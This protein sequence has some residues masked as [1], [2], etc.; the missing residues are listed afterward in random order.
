MDTPKLSGHSI[1]Q[2]Q[3]SVT[4]AYPVPGPVRDLDLEPA[5]EGVSFNLRALLRK[6]WALL[7]ALVVV[8]AGA[9]FASVVL[10]TPMYKAH[11][12]LE[13]QNSPAGAM[14]GDNGRSSSDAQ[15]D[16]QT[17]IAVLRTGQFLKRGADRLQSE[18]VPVAPLGQDLFSHLR[19]RVHPATQDPLE[20]MR[21]GLNVAIGTFDARPVN[22]TRLIE[23]SCDS[24]NPDVAAGFLNAMAAEFVEDT[25]QSRMQ[26]SQ[27]AA[28]W[29]AGQIEETKA[30]V[31]EAEGKLRDFVKESGNRFAG[32]GPEGTLDDAKLAQ[33]KMELAKVQADRIAKQTRYELTLRN[34]S[35]NL[36]AVID[37]AGLRGYEEQINSLKQQKAALEITLTDNNPKV[38]RLDAQLA[39]VENAYKTEL[40]RT[41]AKIKGDY[42]AA[43]QQERLL[44][45]A[46]S[47]QSQAVGSQTGP[48]YQYDAL[49][50]QVE[51]LRQM[52]QSLL[53]QQNQVGLSSSVP[54]NPVRIIEP[55]TRPDT[56]YKPQA[57]LNICFGTLLGFVL[58]GGIV[59]IRE[60]SDSS[61]KKP[62][63]SG[64]LLNATEL[65]VIP[66]LD[67]I[68]QTSLTRKGL[69]ASARL[70]GRSSEN[71]DAGKEELDLNWSSGSFFAES[72]RSTLASILR[73]GHD[74]SLKAILITSAGPSEGKTMVVQ[75]LGRA[76]A[77]SGRRVLLLDADFRRP[78]LHRAFNVPND[79]GLIDLISNAELFAGC[80]SEQPGV[81]RVANNLW[82]LP[83]RPVREELFRHLYSGRLR[84]LLD[85]FRSQYDMVLVDAPPIL[86]LADA[87]IIGP[88]VDSVILVV[89]SGAT[90]RQ[91]AMD[92]YQ[93]IQQDGLPLLGT[94][95]TCWNPTDSNEYKYRYDTHEDCA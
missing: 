69:L 12:M 90:G 54:I 38:Q 25:S 74:R 82:I 36:G 83:N 59:F 6:Y 29:V 39:V 62:G 56:P 78:H 95:L 55:S 66:D 87:R 34:A 23:L 70:F 11:L 88:F 27:R 22:Q 71:R 31:D 92:A 10:S 67:R 13:I 75:N 19:Q 17:Q 40:S 60:R 52:Y 44:S 57:V 84:E 89:R 28:E 76:L 26:S 21:S 58:T 43:A 42:E 35:E 32:Q 79:I 18:S 61:I 7:L 81:T 46:Y 47:S 48:A 1:G 2:S 37:D 85:K 86:H 50:R 8:G 4:R 63:F 65:G 20:S 64:K 94:V 68:S 49:K 16:V 5:V 53:L 30:K 3:L 77:E 24:T 51:T 73:K 14:L 80:H 91:Q 41:V 45:G 33:L 93:C 72:F 15:L 9:G